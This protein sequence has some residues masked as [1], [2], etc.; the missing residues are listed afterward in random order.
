M[1]TRNQ[2]LKSYNTLGVEASSDLFIKLKSEEELVSLI[3][4]KNL[5]ANKV[6]ILGGGSNVLFIQDFEGT[7]IHPE[8]NSITAK[9]IDANNVLVV[10]D[11][12]VEWDKFVE[13]C[14]ENN[15][16]GVE[17]LSNIPGDIGAAPIQ[18]IGAYGVEAKDTIESVR[19]ID[20]NSGDVRIFKNNECGF[21]YRQ[22]IFKEEYKGRYLISSVAFKLSRNPEN[23]KLSYGSVKER[24]LKKGSPCL[25]TVRE[26][27]IEIRKEKLPEPD[28]LGN[29]GSFFKNPIISAKHFAG[30][31]RSFSD[32]PYY[33]ADKEL[34]KIPAAWLIEKCGWKGYRQGDAGVHI[35]QALVIVNYGNASGK[36]IFRLSEEIIES[37]IKKFDIR[38]EREVNVI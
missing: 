27:I 19:A 33:P 36:E 13:Y 6:M 29:A 16:G 22:S 8:M 4:E 24:V 32:M 35:N 2:S 37:V 28:L 34:I 21:A 38:L 11:A 5:S 14:V 10:C 9:N 25:K 31:Q 12:G 1:A 20:L 30:L 3:R 18:N 26:T 23:F 17:N 7:I 15:Y